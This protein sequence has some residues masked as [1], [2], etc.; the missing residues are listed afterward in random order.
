MQLSD[1]QFV[2]L[3]MLAQNASMHRVNSRY[4]SIWDDGDVWGCLEKL[5][6]SSSQTQFAKINNRKFISNINVKN[7]NNFFKERQQYHESKTIMHYYLSPS[8]L[9]DFSY[10]H[11]FTEC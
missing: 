5:T 10:K 6:P 4:S 11:A 3:Q 1:C 7:K 9:P 2:L 8:L